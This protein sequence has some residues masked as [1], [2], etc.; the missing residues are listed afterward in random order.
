MAGPRTDK[1]DYYEVLGL[2]RSANEEDV[3]KAY[4]KKALEFHPDRNKSEGASD[5][6]KE[7]NEAYQILSDPESRARYDRFGHS[8][9]N[10]NAGRGFDGFGDIG[11]FGDI[12]ESFFG[13]ATSTRPARGRDL[14]IGL[15][16]PFRDAVFGATHTRSIRRRVICD[17]CDGSRAEPGATVNQC[18][19]CDGTG[20]VRR[21]AR[22]MFG[23]FEQIS[24][25]PTCEATGSIVNDP[26]KACRGRGVVNRNSTIEITV[27]SGVDDG[28]RII[29]RGHGDVG[30]R[31][32]EPGDLYVRLHIAEDDL[33][34]RRGNDIHLTMELH[35]IKAMLGQTASV[36]TL[37]GD[38]ELEVHAGIQTGETLTIPGAGVPPLHGRGRRGDLI[39]SVYVKTP[40]RFTKRQTELLSE[41]AESFAKEN[42]R[43]L[44]PEFGPMDRRRGGRRGGIWD[45][46]RTAF[47]GE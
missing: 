8:G 1:R 9:V 18:G 35:A 38:V 3:R 4:R 32:G 37:E 6:F 16:V 7:V 17:R 29:M 25:C 46:L 15:E 23:S 19:T 14:E 42:G 47:V 36:P 39:V 22:M 31:G 27:P 10:G 41:L 45:W 13:G 24:D 11:G 34:T 40:E 30:D 12:F 26:C 43:P 21:S 44:D 20:Q 28:T 5:K 33:Y 2:D